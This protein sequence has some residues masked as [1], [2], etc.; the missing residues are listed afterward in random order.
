MKTFATRI[1]NGNLLKIRE[2]IQPE[3]FI[4]GI[5]LKDPFLLEFVNKRFRKFL[6]FN[7]I[8]KLFEWKV[9]PFGL[10]RSPRVVK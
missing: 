4:I 6:H 1:K 8:G 7:W 3:A 2:W 9:I 10:K 5:D